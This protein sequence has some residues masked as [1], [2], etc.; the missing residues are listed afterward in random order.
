MPIPRWQPEV[1]PH[2]CMVAVAPCLFI[3]ASR[4]HETPVDRPG[5]TRLLPWCL[6]PYSE[7][8][9]AVRP[10][11]GSYRDHFQDIDQIRGL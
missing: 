7:V 6:A 10:A 8:H 4:P 1:V 5:D 11:A 9:V 3:L 2:L